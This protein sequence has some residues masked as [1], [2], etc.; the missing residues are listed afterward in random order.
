MLILIPVLYFLGAG[1]KKSRL[2]NKYIP[3]VLGIFAVALSA[4]WAFAATPVSGMQE[5]AAAVLTAVTQGV[6]VAGGRVCMPISCM[7]RPKRRNDR[8]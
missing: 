8:L 3:A 6:L 4:I 5:I 1:L 2:R 7:C